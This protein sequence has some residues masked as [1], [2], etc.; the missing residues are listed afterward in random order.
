MRW[1]VFCLYFFTLTY[2]HCMQD[3]VNDIVFG[4]EKYQ[5]NAPPSCWHPLLTVI[6]E[7]CMRM[8]NEQHKTINFNAIGKVV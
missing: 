1:C 3:A 7:E 8:E 5:P 6:G 2:Y 4:F